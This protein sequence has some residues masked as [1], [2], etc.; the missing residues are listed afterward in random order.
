MEKIFMC[1][2]GVGYHGCDKKAKIESHSGDFFT[3]KNGFGFD[4][5]Q[6]IHA[7][8]VGQSCECRESGNLSVVRILESKVERVV[9]G[10]IENIPMNCPECKEDWEFGCSSEKHD[11]GTEIIQCGGCGKE[12]T[13][14]E[15]KKDK[16]KGLAYIEKIEAWN[17]GGNIW[18]DYVYFKNGL[19]MCIGENAVVL[20]SQDWAKDEYDEEL[21]IME[22]SFDR[23]YFEYPEIPKDFDKKGGAEFCR[24]TKVEMDMGGGEELFDTIH[25][26]NGWQIIIY[27][28]SIAV[29]R[30][31]KDADESEQIAIKELD[32]TKPYSI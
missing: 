31:E 26:T 11:D 18:C 28:W 27:S 20:T 22:V 3:H 9:S 2:W 10:T 4:D 30:P 1:I 17:T 15:P 12:F 32:F 7:L 29:F 13:Y 5:I 24:I 23:P 16:P 6:K 25:L 19:F 14:T 21:D 8:D